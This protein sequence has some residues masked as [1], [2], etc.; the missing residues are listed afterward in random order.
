MDRVIVA[1]FDDEKRAYEGSRALQD[2]H[3]DGSITLYAEAVIAKDSAGQANLKTPPSGAAGAYI[4][5][6]AGGLLGVLGGPA[7]IAAGATSGAIVGAGAN[8]GR[9]GM[10]VDFL[11]EVARHLEPRKAAIVAEI[12]EEWQTPVDTR[13]EALGGVVFR[14]ARIDVETAYVERELAADQAEL[15]TLQAEH[16]RASAERKAN[17]QTKIDMAKR[18]FQDRRDHVKSRVDTVKQEGEAKLAALKKQVTKAQGETKA[19]LEKRVAEVQADYDARAA[20]LK[21]AMG[22]ALAA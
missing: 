7:G 22:S 21:Q 6:L 17:L 18:K 11:Q 14:R 13:M 5:M 16:S 3:D 10:G 19:T 4:G 9:S 1:V 2:L 12:D 20:A 8:V 15:T